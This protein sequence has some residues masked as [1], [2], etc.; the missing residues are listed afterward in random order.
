MMSAVGATRVVTPEGM[1]WTVRRCWLPKRRV[2]WRGRTRRDTSDEQRGSGGDYLDF[3]DLFGIFDGDSPLAVIGAVL[4]VIAI[5]VL[6]WLFLVPLL[7]A[8]LDVVVLIVLA[9][10]GVAGRVVL[11]RPW[12]IEVSGPDQ[13]VS[14]R[15]VGWQKSSQA[16]EE[17]TR[18]LRTGRPVPTDVRDLRLE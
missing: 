7:L 16:I 6:A 12:E 17:V 4:A 5:V 10:V 8:L 14:L 9:L 3:A 2:R 11:H 13:I 15:V 1:A 18:R